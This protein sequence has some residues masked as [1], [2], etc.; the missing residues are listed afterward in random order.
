MARRRSAS[1]ALRG[2]G[3]KAHSE[4]H[5]YGVAVPEGLHEAIED[6]RGNLSKAESLLGCLAIA[7]EYEADS[8]NGPHYPDVAELARELVRQS[9]NNLD[10]LVLQQRMLRNKVKESPD[11]S[12]VEGYSVLDS[13]GMC[14]GVC[15]RAAGGPGTSAV[16]ISL[17]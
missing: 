11:L 4:E 13:V 16:H 5:V 7:M 12:F 1:K 10:S 14:L 15:R 8:D 3:K 2:R 17:G 9:I 6:E